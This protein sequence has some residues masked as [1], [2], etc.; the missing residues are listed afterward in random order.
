MLERFRVY[1]PTACLIS[2]LITI[3]NGKYVVRVLV[4]VNGETLAS[5]LGAADTVESAEDQARERA[6][7]TL[8]LDQSISAPHTSVTLPSYSPTSE[9]IPQSKVSV[10]TSLERNTEES[11]IELSNEDSSSISH[12]PTVSYELEEPEISTPP[13]K[14]ELQSVQSSLDYQDVSYS[15]QNASVFGDNWLDAKYGTDRTE[16]KIDGTEEQL[17]DSINAQ[18]SH[19]N[20]SES[21]NYETNIAES[22]NTNDGIY[23]S[24]QSQDSSNDNA[25]ID[26]L[27]DS[28]G[29]GKE[30]EQDFIEQNYSQ[31]TRSFLTPEELLHFHQYLDVL[32]KV[33][34]ETK[35]QGWKVRQQKDYLEYN[36]KKESLEQLS[37]DE[38]QRFLQYLEVFSK[39]TTEIRRLGWNTIQGKTYLKQNYGEEGRTRLSYEQLQDFLH[40]IEVLD[41]S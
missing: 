34:K 14:E 33:T 19:I 15:T 4:L 36:H 22:T 38:L 21:I 20:I 32:L 2:E 37:V 16:E 29:W 23:S 31:K 25:K 24:N 10:N 26:I 11:A 9:G 1:Y 6:L 30:K 13:V 3:H 12:T 27:I 17:S 7:A 39:T 18:E 40:K 8:P 35:D 28:L 5:G 41:I